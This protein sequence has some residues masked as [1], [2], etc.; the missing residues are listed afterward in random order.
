LLSEERPRAA[1]FVTVVGR[2]VGGVEDR[3]CVSSGE[4]LRAGAAGE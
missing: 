2:L 1:R 4:R 3:S